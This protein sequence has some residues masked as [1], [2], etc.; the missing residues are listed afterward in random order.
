LPGVVQTG[1]SGP[2]SWQYFHSNALGSSLRFDNSDPTTP[3]GR[4]EYDAYGQTYTIQAGGAATYGFAGKHGYQSDYTGQILCGVRYYLPTVGRFL[5]EDPSGQSAGLNLYE[6]CGDNPQNKVDPSGRAWQELSSLVRW[7]CNPT[8]HG[9][10][11]ESQ[12]AIMTT[13][14]FT[15]MTWA[16]HVEHGGYIYAD[17]QWGFVMGTPNGGY[18]TYLT[19]DSHHVDIPWQNNPDAVGW[20][21]THPQMGT[22]GVD[23]SGLPMKGGDG[24]AFSDGDLMSFSQSLAEH[25]GWHFYL[26][27]WL[28]CLRYDRHPADP[29]FPGAFSTFVARFIPS[30][31]NSEK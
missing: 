17:P 24:S 11:S 2:T 30:F 9:F 3:T 28:G 12:C 21:H 19:G 14:F 26:G 15:G 8:L 25:P 29:P 16:D 10:S 20:W 4:Y 7:F 27:C 22:P 1:T 31:E 23:K 6:Y 5:N 13:F 18:G